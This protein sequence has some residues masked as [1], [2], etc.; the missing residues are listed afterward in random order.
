MDLG[1]SSPIFDNKRSKKNINK[2]IGLY[3]FW[4]MI[5]TIRQKLSVPTSL[6][7]TYL[8]FYFIWGTCMNQVGKFLGIAQFTYWWQVITCYC[9][10]MVPV[11]IL[12]RDKSFWMQYVFGVVA[13]APIEFLGYMN[14]T[15]IALN[16]VENGN[17]LVNEGNMLA[18]I[19]DI[20][21]F[22]LIMT[23]FFGL[24]YPLGNIMV[25]AVYKLLQRIR[26]IKPVLNE[27]TAE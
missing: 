9:I 18:N 24:Y 20:K 26:I 3:Y 5:Q 19:V 12:I 4:F 23:M 14:H 6:W 13:I 1:A 15:S 25:S 11:S 21:N 16:I 22:S 17:T 10:C 7:V 8:I 2:T 27:V